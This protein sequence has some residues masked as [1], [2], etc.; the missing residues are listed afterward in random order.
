MSTVVSDVGKENVV[1]PFVPG[2]CVHIVL[3]GSRHFLPLFGHAR[4]VAIERD[5][6]GPVPPLLLL[7]L[8]VDLVQQV[9]VVEQI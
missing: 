3:P 6:V 9:L 1:S 2:V 5:D 8:G 7:D 4:L